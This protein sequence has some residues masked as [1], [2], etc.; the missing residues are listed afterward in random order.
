M[1]RME[2]FFD[3]SCPYCLRGYED[4]LKL[5]PAY[6]AA[7]LVWCPIEAHPRPERW[8]SHSD[9]CVQALL[10]AL[11]NGA[12]PF[13]FSERM[14][15]AI[16]EEH[17]DIESAAV[18]AACFRD[19]LDEN[20]LCCALEHGDFAQQNR[21]ANDYAY[22]QCAV[23]AVPS[24]RMDGHKLDAVEG[25]GVTKEQLRDFLALAK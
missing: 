22:E 24:F 10:F 3:Y 17:I 14:F 9:L 2:F 5:L 11:Q 4:L 6:P 15:R 25:V 16:F 21:D 7:E 13:L 12:D 20:A 23:W 19:L 8:G 1:S 18:L